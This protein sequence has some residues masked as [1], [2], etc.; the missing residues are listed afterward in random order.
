MQEGGTGHIGACEP[1]LESRERVDDLWRLLRAVASV[2][3]GGREHSFRRAGRKAQFYWASRSKSSQ[4][5]RFSPPFV[6]RACVRVVQPATA[7][8]GAGRSQVEIVANC[9]RVMEQILEQTE[10]N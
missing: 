1:A 8:A 10:G 9:G 7:S 2:P 5:G 3:T 6:P 4:L